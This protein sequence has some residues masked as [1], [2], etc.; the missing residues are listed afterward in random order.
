MR[1][2]EYLTALRVWCYIAM[3]V[4]SLETRR[5]PSPHCRDARVYCHTTTAVH[6]VSTPQ[7]PLS[8]AAAAAAAATP[9]LAL[10][11]ANISLA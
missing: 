6:N 3:Y 7:S 1:L 8:P 5:A 4:W 9:F 2:A 10:R 11:A